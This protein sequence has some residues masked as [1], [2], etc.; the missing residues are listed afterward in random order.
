MAPPK[1]NFV[2]K[3]KIPACVSGLLVSGTV[4][5]IV[6]IVGETLKKHGPEPRGF[7]VS[8]GVCVANMLNKSHQLIG[9]LKKA[10]SYE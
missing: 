7:R 10:I 9:R 1:Y 2:E 8:W 5:F 6:Q 4:I 3:S